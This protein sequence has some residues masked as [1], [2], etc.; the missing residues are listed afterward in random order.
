MKKQYPLLLPAAIGML[1][2]I[3]DGQTAVAGVR[4]GV[5]LCIRTLI[6]SLFPFFF[7]STLL[8]GTLIGQPMKLLAPLGSLCG[9]PSGA[10]SLLMVGFLGGYPVG[11]QNVAEAFRRGQI[12]KSDA[13]RMLCFCNNAGPSFIFGMIG[14]MFSDW[15]IPWL[16]W[17]IHIT[18]AILT[19]LVTYEKPLPS[20]F[21]SNK[22]ITPTEALERS[23]KAMATIC[24]WVVLFRMLLAFLDSWF[25]WLV[26][27]TM[28]VLISGFLELSNGCICL[29]IIDSDGLRFTLASIMLALGGI[30]VTM[31]T[32]SVVSGL[33]LWRYLPGKLLQGCFSVL[34]C[35]AAQIL[36]PVEQRLHFHPLILCPEII[37]T[38]VLIM[39]LRQNKKTSSIPGII[40]V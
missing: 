6:P 5:E 17:G 23:V 38:L 4:D 22:Q 14:P 2:L 27:D 29:S 33:S 30:C 3:L 18:G 35:F 36:F 34:L 9:I 28:Q 26:N 12:T 40:G 16:I 39:I 19:A 24:G 37:L 21:S 32:A 15:R 20:T 8:T 1:V 11:A 7:F 31:Q 25:L 10:E 13:E